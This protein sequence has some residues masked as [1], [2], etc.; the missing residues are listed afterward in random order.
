M[1]DDAQTLHLRPASGARA[2]VVR[3]IRET[4]QTAVALSARSLMTVILGTEEA[5]FDILGTIANGDHARMAHYLRQVADFVESEGKGGPWV[6][7]DTRL[8]MRR[9]V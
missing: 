7:V 2:E 6:I 9:G 1:T 8:S 4:E 5:G 3:V